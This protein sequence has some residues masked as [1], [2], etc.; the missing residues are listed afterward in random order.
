MKYISNS[1]KFVTQSWSSFLI[2]SIIFEIAYLHPKLKTWVDLVTMSPIF[3]KFGTQNK[4]NMLI[5]NIV[6]GFDDLHSKL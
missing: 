2:I 1:M 4:L 5:R 3:M 6:H